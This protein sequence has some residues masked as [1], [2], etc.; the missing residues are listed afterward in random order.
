MLG[1]D[2]GQAPIRVG[3]DL[4]KMKGTMDD[5][6]FIPDPEELAKNP[7]PHGSEFSIFD[8]AWSTG[9]D[10]EGA[11]EY[12]SL[13]DVDDFRAM[14]D[15]DGKARSLEVALTAPLMGAKWRIV[16]AEGDTGEAQFVEDFLKTSSLA[17]GM[18]TPFQDVI[19]QATSARTFRK[20]FFEKNYK[21]GA[22]KFDGKIVYDNIAFRPPETCYLWRDDR[23]GAFKGFRQRPVRKTPD[24]N[25]KD[26]KDIVFH[27]PYCW[28]HI[29]GQHRNPLSGISDMQVPLW[30]HKTKQRVLW[31]WTVFLT[32]QAEP[33]T[34][35]ASAEPDKAAKKVSA[36]KGGGTIGIP[37]DAEVTVLEASGTGAQTFRDFIAYLDS[38]MLASNLAGFLDLTSPSQGTGS[39]ALSQDQSSF[40][41]KAE[42]RVAEELAASITRNIVGDLVLLN[43]GQ[44]AAFPSFDFEPLSGDDMTNIM[45]LLQS[46]VADL[47]FEFFSLLAQKVA[48]ALDLDTEVVATALDKAGEVAEQ[49]AQ[50]GLEQQAAQVKGMKDNAAEGPVKAVGKVAN[51]AG[52]V[53]AASAMVAGK[54]KVGAGGGVAPEGSARQQ[55]KSSGSSV[56]RK[57]LPR[58][59]IK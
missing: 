55:A 36:I 29:N 30:C 42:S 2:S 22:G 24:Q 17:G 13:S 53:A 59:T 3:K 52:R 28:V 11:F 44:D 56:A 49:K 37:K 40:F 5:G 35:V 33:R 25:E 43:F 12:A 10:I 58:P 18:R 34:V 31:L 26:L 8:L 32:T 45:A 21:V 27:P 47:P 1:P 6:V 38:M 23:T 46:R 54:Q 48:A 50:M 4:S 15:K 51:A 41:L 57:V 7:E 39:Y 9:W 19:G 20:A 16:P 14:L